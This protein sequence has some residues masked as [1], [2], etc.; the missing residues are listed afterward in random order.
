MTNVWTILEKEQ[1][2]TA[3]LWNL[4]QQSFGERGKK[5][6]WAVENGNVKRYLD[7]FVVVGQTDEYVVEKDFCTCSDFIF[8][9]GECWHIL[10]VKIARLTGQY[11]EYNLWYQ[12]IWEQCH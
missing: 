1:R 7:F 8:R 2:L 3:S 5:A 10:A 12:D 11:E 6:L 9:G 4:I